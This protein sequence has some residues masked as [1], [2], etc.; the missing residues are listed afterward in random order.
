MRN[1]SS[2]LRFGEL[3]LDLVELLP[4]MVTIADGIVVMS[5]EGPVNGESPAARLRGNER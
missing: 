2:H 4:D 5:R 3:M 1:G